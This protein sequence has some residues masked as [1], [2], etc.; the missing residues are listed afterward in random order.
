MRKK[1][2]PPKE[3]CGR[4]VKAAMEVFA[5]RGFDG[6]T[7]RDLAQN[8]NVALS[9][10]N[11]HYGNKA[12]LYQATAEHAADIMARPLQYRLAKAQAVLQDKPNQ[13]QSI[14]ELVLLTSAVAAAMLAPGEESKLATE[15][16]IRELVMR[17]TGA[18]IIEERVLEP[19]LRCSMAFLD[20]VT[21]SRTDTAT[22]SVYA[23]TLFGPITVYRLLHN[24]AVGKMNE[25]Q[26]AAILNVICD[27]TRL[28]ILAL[29]EGGKS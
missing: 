11:Y 29:A 2:P 19:I 8:A 6:A 23:T 28:N 20:I 24:H 17:G 22:L 16:A 3:T 10:I 25:E 7:T 27:V 21:Q 4:L 9:A 13:R 14:D 1:E 12:G 26:V 18:V 15:F 5:T